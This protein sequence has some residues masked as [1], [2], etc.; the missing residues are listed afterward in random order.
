M[1]PCRYQ[2][3]LSCLGGRSTVGRDGRGPWNVGKE[4]QITV[5]RVLSEV[6]GLQD[7]AGRERC[8]TWHDFV[9]GLGGFCSAG[10][11]G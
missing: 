3:K 6:P 5:A 11:A 4:P 10:W 7:E 9:P 1:R 2:A 8:H